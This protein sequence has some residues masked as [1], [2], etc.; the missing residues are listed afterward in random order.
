M[1]NCGTNVKPKRFMQSARDEG[2]FVI[3]VS[4]LLT[5]TMPVMAKLCARSKP[6]GISVVVDGAPLSAEFTVKTSAVYTEGAAEAAGK[7]VEI[8][9]SGK[10]LPR[11]AV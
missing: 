11:G 1:V 3:C 7:T 10:N 2:A 8:L 6:L 9:Q 4:A 5:T